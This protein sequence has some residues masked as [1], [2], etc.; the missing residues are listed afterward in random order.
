MKGNILLIDDNPIDIKVI[1]SVLEK[2]GFACSGFTEYKKA[3]FWLESNTA[4]LIF[5]DLQMPGV[6]GYEI[7]TMLRKSPKTAKTPIIIVSGK[8]QTEDV[9]K[10]IQLGA[11][12]YIVKPVDPLVL[13]EKIQKMENPDDE[14]FHS[15][16][17]GNEEGVCVFLLKPL[18]VISVSEFGLKAHSDYAVAEGEV[19]E[20]GGLPSDFFG[21]EKLLLKCLSCE[22]K[23]DGKGFLMQMTYTG[24]TEAQ[25]QIIRKSCRH[26]WIQTKQKVV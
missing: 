13:Q 3:L 2:A 4:R 21:S 18:R 22:A 16:D 10:A 5:L 8:N 7:I 19:L 11:N 25:R 14:N 20:L 1:S 17:I 6:S 23:E 24:M 15:V 12:D 26:V 9:M